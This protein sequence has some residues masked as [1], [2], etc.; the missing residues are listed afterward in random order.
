MLTAFA[1]HEAG[2]AEE[3]SDRKLFSSAIRAG[4][5]GDVQGVRE[6]VLSSIC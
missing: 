2:V 4:L 5:L 3:R 6:Q 1:R